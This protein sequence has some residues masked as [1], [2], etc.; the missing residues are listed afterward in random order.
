MVFGVE[1]GREVWRRGQMRIGFVE[2][3]CF[4]FGVKAAKKTIP[5]EQR[6]NQKTIWGTVSK[7][8]AQFNS[9]RLLIYDKKIEPSGNWGRLLVT[10]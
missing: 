9:F 1:M 7:G 6:R 3:Q 2:E 8:L 10:N 5:R 4:K